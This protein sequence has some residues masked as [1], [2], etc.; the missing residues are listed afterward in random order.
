MNNYE[1]IKK[2]LLMEMKMTDTTIKGIKESE[3]YAFNSAFNSGIR[4]A[5]KILEK[6]K[7]KLN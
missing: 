7:D 6:Y 1:N 5:L 4:S 3:E 2:E